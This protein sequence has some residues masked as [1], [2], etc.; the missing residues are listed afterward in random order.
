MI[1][2][3]SHK[4]VI[5]DRHNLYKKVQAKIRKRRTHSK[6]RGGKKK[7][8]VGR[9]TPAKDFKQND[10]IKGDNLDLEETKKKSSWEMDFEFKQRTA[11]ERKKVEDLFDYEGCKVGRGTYGHVYK[12]KSKD[13]FGFFPDPHS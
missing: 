3:Q 8:G 12:G 1:A 4:E 13:R 2:I 10:L 11:S 9:F 6:N 5:Q 7:N